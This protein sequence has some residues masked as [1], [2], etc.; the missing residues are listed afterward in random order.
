VASLEIEPPTFWLVALYT[1]NTDYRR[2]CLQRCCSIE[3][4][5]HVVILQPLFDPDAQLRTVFSDTLNICS[6]GTAGTIMVLYI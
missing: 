3:N 6:S 1:F 5:I 2:L 4:D